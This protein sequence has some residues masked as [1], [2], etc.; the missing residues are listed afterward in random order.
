MSY[1]TYTAESGSIVSLYKKGTNDFRLLN[2]SPPIITSTI[3]FNMY[4]EFN[5]NFWIVNKINNQTD[6]A[7]GPNTIINPTLTIWDTDILV[8]HHIN[9]GPGASDPTA[10]LTLSST[11]TVQ[12]EP[13]TQDTLLY[14]PASVGETI[15][16]YPGVGNTGTFYYSKDPI[17]VNYI[18]GQ[19]I[20]IPNPTL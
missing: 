5:G 18:G 6:R 19:I 16:W 20:V 15:Q 14:N 8:L 7:G 3:Q 11:N 13:P 2:N 4:L 9:P 10:I 1:T 12:V 17:A